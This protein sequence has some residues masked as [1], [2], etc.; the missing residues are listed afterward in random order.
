M[1][2]VEWD[3]KVTVNSSGAALSPYI[4]F[5]ICWCRWTYCTARRLHMGLC[6]ALWWVFLILPFNVWVDAKD[7]PQCEWE[8]EFKQ[9][10]SPCYNL[11]FSMFELSAWVLCLFF[12]FM[13]T[14]K[15]A[16]PACAGPM[17]WSVCSAPTARLHTCNSH[18]P[19]NFGR[20]KRN[21]RS[22]RLQ[23]GE[24]WHALWGHYHF[25]FL[26]YLLLHHAWRLQAI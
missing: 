3:G 24:S 16:W 9:E 8:L 20:R 15:P 18:R 12:T 23:I 19:L 17:S 26:V 4:H 14:G 7:T 10:I 21:S 6:R 2:S 25:F 1:F 22:R 13:V 5:G 11:T